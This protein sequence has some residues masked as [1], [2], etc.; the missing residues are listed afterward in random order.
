MST[1]K[2]KKLNHILTTTP[3]GVVLL[4]SWLIEN[5]YS[6]DL[7]QRYRKSG[8]L[9]SIGV[10]ANVFSG[11]TVDYFGALY[12]LQAQNNN[13]IHIGARSAFLLL[14]KSHYLELDTKKI[15]LFTSNANRNL[16][17]W[18]KNYTWQ[19]YI[20]L[21]SSDFIS[22]DIGLVD[23]QVKEF[24]IKISGEI[25]A[26]ME[27]LYLVPYHQELSECYELMESMNNLYPKKVQEL[28]E[29][30]NSIKVK[31]LFLYLAEKV[32]HE[33]FNHLDL[34]RINLGT[35]KRQIV[36]DGVLDKK[37]QITIPKS[38]RKL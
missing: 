6:S 26:F 12:A 19:V 37:Y 30:C 2:N 23:I 36:E 33:W 31:R 8:W 13:H 7:I 17:T 20:E 22:P 34:S 24:S 3:K 32:G 35:G 15:I 9:E 27:C 14:G 28:L 16:P 25:R 5:G 18:F 1:V 29:N 38:L 21:H 4:S 11:D 10:G